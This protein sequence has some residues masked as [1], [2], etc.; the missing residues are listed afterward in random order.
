MHHRPHRCSEP[1]THV[2]EVTDDGPGDQ[3]R[4][5]A[6]AMFEPFFTTKEVGEGT[7]LGLSISLGIAQ[8]HG[9]ALT[10]VRPRRKGACFQLDAAGARGA[11]RRL[12]APGTPPNRPRRGGAPQALVVEDEEPIAARCSPLARRDYE[13]VEA[14]RARQPR[15]SLRRAVRLVLCDVQLATATAASAAA[16]PRRGSRGWARR[17]IFVTGD[18]GAPDRRRPRVRRLPGPDQALHC[19]RSRFASS[20]MSKSGS[21]SCN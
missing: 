19:D 1:A 21:D 13:V 4:S 7:G 9:G 16:Y 12:A 20:G 18:I 10:A 2:V 15:R 17:V 3:R 11:R 6:A 14:P 8:A 5:C